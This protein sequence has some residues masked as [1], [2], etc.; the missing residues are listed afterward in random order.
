MN[1]ILRIIETTEYS[2]DDY[3]NIIDLCQNKI[4]KIENKENNKI[5]LNNLKKIKI[6]NE[7]IKHFF[8]IIYDS[9]KFHIEKTN[10]NE[11]RTISISFDY[12]NY[13]IDFMIYFDEYDSVFYEEKIHIVNRLTHKY[14][15]FF[16]DYENKLINI[17]ELITVNKID[18]NS[19]IKDLFECV[20]I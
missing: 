20:P 12:K 4:L 18:I 5:F 2:I 16:K 7:E 8:D 6:K 3:N 19:F 1:N 17:L 10:Y 11:I 13:S 15:T 9:F 14:E